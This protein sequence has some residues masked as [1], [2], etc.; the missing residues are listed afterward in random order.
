MRRNLDRRIEAITPIEDTKLKKQ[1]LNL[2]NIYLKDSFFAWEM[3]NK[4]NYIKRKED[5]KVH[6]SQFEL[7]DNWH[8]SL[9][10]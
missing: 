4:G 8:K 7:I 5:E 9:D 10:I 3:N 1:L 6:R 2:L